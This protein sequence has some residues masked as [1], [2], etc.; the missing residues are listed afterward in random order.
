[1]FHEST[2]NTGH[3]GHSGF[4]DGRAVGPVRGIGRPW[5]SLFDGSTLSGWTKAGKET[6]KWE[7][8]DGAIVGTGD[9]SML[10]SPKGDYQNFKFRAEVKINDHGNSGLYFRCRS[11]TAISARDT[12][13]RSTAPTATR[14]ELA[15]FTASSYVRTARAP[16]HLVHLRDR[17]R[18][19]D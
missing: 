2:E 19:K 15:R 1:M 5:V 3:A 17:M 16:G 9:S 6:S 7:V 13:P 18:D 11:P 14:S 8:V 4:L 10:Y 12:R